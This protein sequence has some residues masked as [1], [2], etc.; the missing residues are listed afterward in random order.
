MDTVPGCI[1]PAVAKWSSDGKVLCVVQDIAG[2]LADQIR[3]FQWDYA[4]DEFIL[5]DQGTFTQLPRGTTT[6]KMNNHSG[7]TIAWPGHTYFNASNQFCA[8]AG[9]QSANALTIW[10]RTLFSDPLLGYQ[11]VAV[12]DISVSGLN[13][14]N[15]ITMTH[16]TG[17]VFPSGSGYLIAIAFNIAPRVE[18]Y[19]FDDASQVL[20]RKAVLPGL[21]AQ[22]A[23]SIQFEQGGPYNGGDPHLIIGF[24]GSPY[25]KAYR[26][27]A[28]GAPVAMSITGTLPPSAVEALVIYGTGTPVI[29]SGFQYQYSYGLSG[30]VYSYADRAGISNGPAPPG[31]VFDLTEGN[32]R[33]LSGGGG[34]IDQ[35]ITWNAGGVWRTTS[36]GFPKTVGSTVRSVSYNLA[37][38]YVQINRTAPDLR[39]KQAVTGRERQ[40]GGFQTGRRG[41]NAAV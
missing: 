27:L 36:E 12:G 9:Y 32:Q 40:R 24:G 20:V 41:R 25:L 16:S 10:K 5:L 31:G 23:R 39:Q 26:G 13:G 29:A 37:Y 15:G 35:L 1:A 21:P 4:G 30:G 7:N 28:S 19:T 8:V 22:Q 3:F 6:I 14:V 11:V 33:I 38:F 17:S 2:G 18:W 34:A